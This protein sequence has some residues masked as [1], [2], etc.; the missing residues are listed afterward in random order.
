MNQKSCLL[1]T[2]I[3]LMP[4]SACAQTRAP[5]GEDASVYATS[6]QSILDAKCSSCHNG[7]TDD[8]SSLRLDSWQNVLA[9]SEFGEVVIPF[10]AD[11]SVLVEII[12]KLKGTAHP[13]TPD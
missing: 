13:V 10:N 8:S 2:L 4:I 6:V 9:G 11:N 3:V 5:G 7:S 1:A 12:E